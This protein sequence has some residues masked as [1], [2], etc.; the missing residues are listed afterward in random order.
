MKTEAVKTEYTYGGIIGTTTPKVRILMR[1]EKSVIY[2]SY[3]VYIAFR[4]NLNYSTAKFLVRDLNASAFSDPKINSIVE[5]Y[6]GPG[7]T[8]AVIKAFEKR[9]C[10]TVLFEGGGKPFPL[11]RKELRDNT[12]A[13]WDAV[14][15]TAD[16]PCNLDKCVE[17]GEDLIPVLEYHYLPEGARAKTAEDCARY[18]NHK[19]ACIKG[20]DTR[21]NR[22]L[23][24]Y[25]YSY[26][27]W[28]E[29]SYKDEFFCS[30]KCAASYGRKAAREKNGRL[31][32]P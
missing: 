16:I 1:S 4:S 24:P 8:S 11:P 20:H 12:Q 10:G 6:F 14:T 3:G 25:I 27:T 28:D 23:W 2:V 5:A 30:V 19:I 26:Q 7:S 18:T 29:V 13:E 32:R 17:C 31:D 22:E 21:S 9:G 15:P